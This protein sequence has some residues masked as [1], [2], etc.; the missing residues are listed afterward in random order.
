MISYYGPLQID[1]P[2]QVPT[3]GPLVLQCAATIR[4]VGPRSVTVAAVDHHGGPGTIM[5]IP[6]GQSM[7]L[8]APPTGLWQLVL[9]ETRQ[10]AGT[11]D[12]LGIV[13]LG[14]LGLA[15]YGGVELVRGQHH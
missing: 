4:N 13:A 8:G 3:V 1:S 14:I 7:T 9:V 6:P 12:S 15:I 11:V 5:A 2:C 10:V